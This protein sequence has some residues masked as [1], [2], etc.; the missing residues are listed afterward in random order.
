MTSEVIGYAPN[1]EITKETRMRPFKRYCVATVVLFAILILPTCLLAA[2]VESGNEGSEEIKTDSAAGSEVLATVNGDPITSAEVELLN[3]R[4]AGR[5]PKTFILE[6]LIQRKAVEQLLEKEKIEADEKSI[7]E[8]MEKI[9]R[10]YKDKGMSIDDALE[11][12]GIP[13]EE[14]REQVAF[15][16]RL[17]KLVESRVTEEE[18]QKGIDEIK[19]ELERVRASHILIATEDMSEEEAQ[20]KIEGIEK[21]LRDAKDLKEA[22]AEAAGKYSDCPSKSKGGDLGPFTRGRMVKEFSDVAFS[23]EVGQ[24]SKPV[25]TKF[26]YHLILLTERIPVDDEKFE[27]QKEA[28]KLRFLQKKTVELVNEI[29]ES[30]E[31][32][33]LDGDE[34]PTEEKKEEE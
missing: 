13:K 30:A 8:E 10:F 15:Q 19:G 14:L 22:F 4:A 27:Q 23:L 34:S 18:T 7:D 20:K 25:L 9:T 31:V 12:Q 26:G 24:M 29:T 11:K 17:R 28:V 2:E 5:M 21:E 32:V 3:K 6:Q 16:V 33:R 1:S